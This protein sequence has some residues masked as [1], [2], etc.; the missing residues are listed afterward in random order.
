MNSTTIAHT[1]CHSVTRENRRAATGHGPATSGMS[2]HGAMPARTG[3]PRAGKAHNNANGTVLES[4]YFRTFRSH[5]LLDRSE[6][7]ALARCIDERSQRIRD[8][9]ASAMESVSHLGDHPPFQDALR[10]LTSIRALSGL[11]AP[12]VDEAQE[13]LSEMRDALTTSGPTHR[14]IRRHLAT[15]QRQVAADRVALEQAKDTLVQRNLRLVV[16]IAKRFT[17]RGMSLLDLIQEGNIGLM[18][19]AE[20]F[21]YRK[22][23]KFSTYATWWVRQGISRAIADQVRTIRIPVH[24]TEAWQRMVKTSHR[25]A[26]QLG[27]EPRD[28]EIAR[29]MAISPERVRHTMQAFLEPVSLDHPRSD[30]EQVLGECLPNTRAVPVDALLQDEQQ[31]AQLHHMFRVLSPRE[32][33]VL[34]LR[35][36]IGDDESRTLDEV[37]AIMH[38]SRERIR[39]IEALALKKLR[40]PATKAHLA[41]IGLET[42]HSPARFARSR[43]KA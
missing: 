35:F 29:T 13:R 22:G 24:A 9:L 15:L 11:S 3:K 12:A 14:M 17:G 27:R 36:G 38:V 26:Q 39:Q 30:G 8:T 41:A 2:G 34:R 42:G 1:T 10:S 31:K 37:G 28:E 33:Q 5:P 19:A 4:V 32:E 7:L 25:L 16:D 6:E 18:R 23:F 21:Q 43:R 40:G 20:R